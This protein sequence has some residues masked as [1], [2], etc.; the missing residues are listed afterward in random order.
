MTTKQSIPVFVCGGCLD[1]VLIMDQ[2]GILDGNWKKIIKVLQ[3]AH[4]R[5]V[6]VIFNYIVLLLLQSSNC[7]STPLN[8]CK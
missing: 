1:H 3:E 5:K 6:A 2:M 8:D 4:L 7:D